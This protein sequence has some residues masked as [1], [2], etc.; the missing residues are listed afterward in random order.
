M[1]C[2]R[3]RTRPRPS[4]FSLRGRARLVTDR[5]LRAAVAAVWSFEPDDAYG[6][7]EFDI[8]A[9]VARHATDRGRLAAGLHVVAGER[10]LSSFDRFSL[11]RDRTR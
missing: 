10:R 5:A 1:R 11:A 3:T 7:F 6:L 2:T 9:A 8:D 4:E